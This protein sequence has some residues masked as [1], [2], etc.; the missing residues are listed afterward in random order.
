MS[1]EQKIGKTKHKINQYDEM[2]GFI[3]TEEAFCIVL[4]KILKNRA[5]RKLHRLHREIRATA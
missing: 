4:T 5:E 3:P 2:L 1:L